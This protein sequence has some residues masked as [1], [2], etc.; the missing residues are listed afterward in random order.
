MKTAAQ[1][2]LIGEEVVSK[3]RAGKTRAALRILQENGL[4]Q[5]ARMLEEPAT[6]LFSSDLKCP[7]HHATIATGCRL[8]SCKFWVASEMGN[9]C[10]LAYCDQQKVSSLSPDE[11][12][13]LYGQPV[14]QV[15][16]ELERALSTLR[17]TAIES[18]A[19]NDPDLRRVFWFVETDTLC[20]VC[21]STTDD[22]RIK[23]PETPLA[24]CSRDC[25]EEI[26]PDVVSLEFK[27]GR[28]ISVM[29]RWAIQ[30]FK[31]LP[32]LERTL[33]LKRETLI[34]LC[35]QHLARDLSSYFPKMKVQS[36]RQPWRRRI[37]RAAHLLVLDTMG[38]HTNAQA[39][40]FGPP[41]LQVDDLRNRLRAVLA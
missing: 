31:S 32:V 6:Q 40:H 26:R 12:A 22:G 16:A 37:D 35:R 38:R 1:I 17:M 30:H 3:L 4:Y 20:C 7:A 18:D 15:R 39:K 5:E 41:I 24:Y 2:D 29:I 33:G 14:D 25:Q 11:I 28:P 36:E 10:V 34:E 19:T 13:Y 8:S 27:F 21:G 23:I 9:N